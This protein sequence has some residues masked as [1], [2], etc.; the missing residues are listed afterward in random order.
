MAVVNSKFEAWA[1]T[2]SVVAVVSLSNHAVAA[3]A[4]AKPTRQ[5]AALAAATESPLAVIELRPNVHLITGAGANIVVQAGEDGVMVVGAGDGR[6]TEEVLAEIRKLSAGP[7]RYVIN[8]SAALSQ[9]GGNQ[10]IAT[11]G[12]QFGRPATGGVFS[13]GAMILSHENVTFRLRDLPTEAWPGE[14]YLN[15]KKTMFVNGEGIEVAY[16]P[17]AHSDGDSTVFFRRTDVIVVGELIDA[18]RFPVIDVENGGSVQGLLKALNELIWQAIPQT[19][20]A[21]RDGGTL[22]VPARGRV[23]ERDDIV[24]YR[25][26]VTIIRDR[27]QVLIDQGKTL[28]QVLEANPAKG[29]VAWYGGDPTWSARH[30]VEAVYLSLARIP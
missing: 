28:P 3:Q 25:D 4:S 13:D 11:A 20:L 27:V 21:W 5:S 30:F 16:R 2:L 26:M 1:A 19:P 22:V 10:V 29:Y 9:I 17:A 8:T 18:N 14:T 23:Y 6:R 12:R 15:E 7:I 24:Q